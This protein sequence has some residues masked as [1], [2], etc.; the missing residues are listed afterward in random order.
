[1]RSLLILFIS[2][3]SAFGFS[4]SFQKIENEAAIKNMIFEKTKSTKSIVGNFHETVYSS[5]YNH[6]KEA[7]GKMHYVN[8]ERLRWE[9]LKPAAKILLIDGEEIRFFENGEEV[10]N[11]GNNKIVKRVKSIMMQMFNGDFLSGKDFII[12]YYESKTQYKIK[13][14]PK[15]NRVAKHMR[16]IELLFNKATLQLDRLTLYDTDEDKI[17]YSFSSVKFD[18]PIDEIN[19][20]QF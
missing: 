7:E 14:A 15:S 18:E 6:P 16:Y 12:G 19:F 10:K 5:M 2:F 8:P 9:H 4:Q 17:V 20:T 11:V 3:L 1:M 13:L